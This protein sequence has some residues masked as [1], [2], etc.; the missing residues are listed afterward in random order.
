MF[1]A[2]SGAI[3]HGLLQQPLQPLADGIA[4]LDIMDEIRRQACGYPRTH[5]LNE[6]PDECRPAARRPTAFLRRPPL[7]IGQRNL[8][9]FRVSVN[10]TAAA[11]GMLSMARRTAHQ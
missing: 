5:G 7:H 3:T 1:R 2:V 9:W 6:V 8:Q 11:F 4:V 10:A